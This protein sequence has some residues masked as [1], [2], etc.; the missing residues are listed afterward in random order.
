MKN[1][2]SIGIDRRL[3]LPWLES[4]ANLV[5]SGIQPKEIN[6]T[7]RELLKDKLASGGPEGRGSLEK[8]ITILMR[9]WAT[10]P[11]PLQSFRDA[12]L[13][14]LQAGPQKTAI[15]VHWGMTIAV[16]PFWGIV[17]DI[18]GRLLT[19]QGSVT[20]AQIL[21]RV[22]EQLGERE[23]ANR[24]AQR[25]IRSYVDWGVLKDSK[26]KGLYEM[27]PP[28]AITDERL[29]AWL[30]EATLRASGL[31]SVPLKILINSP[32]FF[33]FKIETP[34]ILSLSGRVELLRQGVDEDIVMLRDGK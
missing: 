13:T 12:G 6:N 27:A 4:T 18:T 25:A 2:I 24:S 10:T 8:T 34:P 31:N 7:L 30:I 33:P 15:S 14:L 28:I 11:E 19:L 17:A 5:L 16:Y 23:T 29:A 9:I 22:R 3:Q 20:N 32:S 21:R 1:G 26:E